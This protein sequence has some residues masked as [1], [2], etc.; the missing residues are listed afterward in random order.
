VAISGCA[1]A[2]REKV[3]FEDE[4]KKCNCLAAAIVRFSLAPL[5]EDNGPHCLMLC[6]DLSSI[7]S[8][9][10]VP[11]VRLLLKPDWKS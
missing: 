9:V 3:I 8:V 2:H 10:F 7:H 6:T 4:A 5:S 11:G 1:K